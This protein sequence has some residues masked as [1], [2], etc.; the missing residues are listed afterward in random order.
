VKVVK[1]SGYGTPVKSGRRRYTEWRRGG[2]GGE[3]LS[4]WSSWH[5]HLL[6]GS[7]SMCSS[8]FLL[9][10]YILQINRPNLL[11]FGIPWRSRVMELTKTSIR[12]STFE[13]S[14]RSSFSRHLRSQSSQ[15]WRRKDRDEQRQPR[16]KFIAKEEEIQGQ[17]KI[18][19]TRRQTKNSS[20][21]TPQ[22]AVIN[23][24]NQVSIIEGLTMKSDTV[25]G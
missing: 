4:P 12:T 24:E 1:M 17:G 10:K 23:Y 16:S 22:K 21:R 8:P 20:N 15:K 14:F 2:A 25:V 13:I 18:N 9:L 19:S 5:E 6:I 11:K 3:T 7:D